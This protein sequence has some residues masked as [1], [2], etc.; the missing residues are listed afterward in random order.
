MPATPPD[1]HDRAPADDGR[2]LNDRY[3]LVSRLGSGG[4]ADVFLAEDV[5]LGRQVAVKV[6]RAPYAADDEFVERFRIEAQAAAL[7]SHP[8]IVAVHDRGH[9]DG[10]WYLVMEYVRGETLK[11]R[12]RREGRLAPHEA[13]S[14]AGDLLAA[15]QAAHER[16]IVHRD[17]SAQN[18]LLADDGR[19]KVAD[20]GIARIGASALTR[21]GMMMGTCHYISPEQA[22]GLPADERSDVYGAGVVLYEMLTGRVPFA[23]DSDVA[24]ALKHVEEPPPRPRDLEPGVPAALEGVVLRALAKDPAERYQT[25][26]AFAAALRA[27]AAAAAAETAQAP[28]AETEQAPAA[29][30][31][32]VPSSPAPPSATVV[33]GAASPADT[34]VLQGA[35]A[36]TAALPDAAE[37]VVRAPRR[38][39]GRR[40][41]VALLL[42]VAAGAAGWAFY[43]FVIDAGVAV[44]ALVGRTGAE[45]RKLVKDAGLRAV[46]HRDYVDGVGA[47]AV[48]RQRPAAG[49]SVDDGARVDFW[50]SLGPLHVPAPD[51]GGLSGAEAKAQLTDAGLVPVRRTG[52]SDAVA[53]GGVYRQ[54][55]AAGVTVARGDT[56][57]YWVSTGPPLVLVP[58]VVG[59]SS[60]DATA[61][62]EDSG[63]TVEIDVVFGWG[64]YPDTVVEQDPAGG[65]KAADGS[66][67]TISVA[68]F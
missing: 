59:L 5:R 67:V 15:L 36:A 54:K 46:S 3:R 27:A 37:T 40:L 24:V 16:H 62:L 23:A 22:R 41:L 14:I 20:F 6:L 21:S 48:A 2:L 44:P 30:S 12:V 8:N 50:V 55:P 13:A 68:V 45:A 58:D 18:V 7:L 32:P 10:H 38:R 47:G 51:V 60:G 33:A 39:F 65:A 17:V 43:A 63:F 11:H 34:V 31:P 53:M 49:T 28:A 57:I 9:D 25:A 26:A 56:V 64:E 35:A 42:L 66:A 52:R 19:V 61:A 29:Q 4:M 1:T